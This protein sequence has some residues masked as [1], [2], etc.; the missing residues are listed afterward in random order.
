MTP[1]KPI[2]PAPPGQPFGVGVGKRPTS[3]EYDYAAK[4]AKEDSAKA[5]K[6]GSQ[7]DHEEAAISHREAAARASKEGGERLHHADMRA[8]HEKAAAAAAKKPNPL[9][10]W[11]GK[12]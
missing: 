7:K 3:D 2:N 1:L 6:T 4:R 8:M 11:A 5:K 9:K 10:A 12:K